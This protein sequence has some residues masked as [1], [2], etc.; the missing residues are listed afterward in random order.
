[1]TIPAF[2][3]K[4]SRR[5]ARNA[6][7]A[8]CG[9]QRGLDKTPVRRDTVIHNNHRRRRGGK[10]VRNKPIIMKQD[11]TLM[12]SRFELKYLIPNKVALRVRDFVQQHLELDEYGVSQPNLSYPVHSLY[13]DSDDWKIYWR[14]INGDRNR[15]KLRVRY[16][17][18]DPA[19][20]VFFEIKRRC[21]DVILKNRCAVRREA[22][23]QLLAGQLPEPSH[24]ISPMPED[25]DSIQRFLELML[26]L[27]AKPKMHVA[28]DREA[29]IN[30]YNNEVRITMDRHVRCASRLDGLLTTKMEDPYVCTNSTVILELKFTGRFPHWYRELVRTF[31][32]FQC[33]AAKFIEGS[34]LHKGR[35][36]PPKDVIRNMIL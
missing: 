10:A 3:A 25:F 7:A 19:T 11:H 33:G 4:S 15:Y 24:L 13:L 30:S 35:H 8:A 12:A 22:V 5:P 23:N 14:T 21:K 26:E 27:N 34:T 2:A 17:N 16:Y 31:D 36:L 1:M 20:P 29:Y 28:Y 9:A 32:C 18:N 6:R